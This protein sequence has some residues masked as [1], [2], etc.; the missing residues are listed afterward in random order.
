MCRLN[1]ATFG[2]IKPMLGALESPEHCTRSDRWVSR[3]GD[4]AAL[5]AQGFRL[6]CFSGWRGLQWTPSLL[7]GS[8]PRKHRPDEYPVC[9]PTQGDVDYLGQ[10]ARYVTQG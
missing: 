3:K 7:N 2:P 8:K 10:V 5:S 6:L 4:V 1:A 9:E